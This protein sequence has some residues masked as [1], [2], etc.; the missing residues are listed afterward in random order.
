MKNLE[1]L[2]SVIEQSKSHRLFMADIFKEYILEYIKDEI[3][4]FDFHLSEDFERS[5]CVYLHI[6][7]KT[8]INDFYTIVSE[9]NIGTLCI[10]LCVKDNIEDKNNVVARVKNVL[11][12]I[13]Y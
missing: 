12:K 7:D 4:E 2:R 3:K 1:I 13:Y 5:S 6:E 11:D 8:L 10:R 9:C